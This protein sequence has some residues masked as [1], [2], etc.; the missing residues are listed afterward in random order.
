[1]GV[2]LMRAAEDVARECGRSLLVLDTASGDAERLYAR[3][4]WQ[5]VGAIPAFA[6]LPHG[7]LCATSYFYRL[8]GD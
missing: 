2:A 4:G 7:G 8:L 6:L 5:L 3:T 1:V